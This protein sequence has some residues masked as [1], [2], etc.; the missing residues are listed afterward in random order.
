MTAMLVLEIHLKQD[1]WMSC[2]RLAFGELYLV[3]AFHSPYFCLKKNMKQKTLS[4]MSPIIAAYQ[5][6]TGSKQEFC[7][8]HQIAVHT[9]DYWRRKLISAPSSPA[10]TGNFVAL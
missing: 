2:E 5:Q 8:V 6:R 4:E 7:A 3:S 10:S 9:L 1:F